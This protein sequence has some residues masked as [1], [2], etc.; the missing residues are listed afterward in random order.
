M[1][2]I[3]IAVV[4]A[5][6]IVVAVALWFYKKSNKYQLASLIVNPDGSIT[7]TFAFSTLHDQDAD[8]ALPGKRLVLSTKA[9]GK[10]YTSVCSA[11]TASSSLATF[12]TPPKAIKTSS[13]NPVDY[14]SQLVSADVA[15]VTPMW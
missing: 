10:I 9:L 8:S 12:M 15:I 1:S 14:T 2:A 5:L 11:T 4:I 6:I 7:G 13:G 3:A